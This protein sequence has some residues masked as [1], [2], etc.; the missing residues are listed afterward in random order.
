MDNNQFDPNNQ[1][2]I[3]FDQEQA[4]LQFM[5]EHGI[6]GVLMPD[7]LNIN[8]GQFAKNDGETSEPVL[9]MM[10]G[11]ALVPGIP[12]VTPLGLQVSLPPGATPENSATPAMVQVMLPIKN[13]EWLRDAIDQVIA[14]VAEEGPES[15]LDS[16][17]EQAVKHIAPDTDAGLDQLEALANGEEI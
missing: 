10:I 9:G 15:L 14:S 6:F 8:V 13:L 16:A 17:I 7:H 5:A 11:G 1:D 3:G 4:Y 12:V 2:N